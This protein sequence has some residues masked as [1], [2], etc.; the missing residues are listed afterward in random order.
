[1][2]TMATEQ[3]RNGAVLDIG[4][5]G[6]QWMGRKLV[7]LVD[8]SSFEVGFLGDFIFLQLFSIRQR[9]NI[10]DVLNLSKCVVFWQEEGGPSGTHSKW[11]IFQN[12]GN[13]G[14]VS[15]REAM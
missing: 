13:Y 3:D 1:M 10:L 7:D 12:Y 6:K 8:F 9:V 2:N 14:Y 15:L 4:G 11:V 5:K